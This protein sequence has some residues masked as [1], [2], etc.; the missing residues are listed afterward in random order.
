AFALRSH[1]RAEAAQRAG[2]FTAEIEPVEVEGKRGATAVV[3][4]DEH[5]RAGV[6]LEALAKLPPVFRPQGGT[7]HAGN[8]SG[9]TD[10]AAALLLMTEAEV[11]RRGLPVL[12]WL[13]ASATAGVSPR[14]M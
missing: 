1:Q 6:T 14:I 8:S 12:G 3:D 7:V 4:S 9:I 10:G 11:A 2:R 5:V 13:G